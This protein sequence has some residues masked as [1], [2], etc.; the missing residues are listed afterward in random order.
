MPKVQQENGSILA[1][2][3][4]YWAGTHLPEN[5]ISL[6]SGQKAFLGKAIAVGNDACASQGV[7]CL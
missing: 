1:M 2:H 3:K 5:T 4:H 7:T 6:S